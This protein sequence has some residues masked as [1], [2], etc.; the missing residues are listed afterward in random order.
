M[1]YLNAKSYCLLKNSVMNFLGL[2][3]QDY[4]KIID[5][6]LC[7]NDVDE[8]VNKIV[9][10]RVKTELELIQMF[11]LSRRLNNSNL[12][13]NENLRN[14]LL[15]KS[16][17]TE[18]FKQY[19]VS[20][21]KNNNKINLLYKNVVVNISN[22]KYDDYNGNIEFRLETDY[23]INGFAFREDLEKNDYYSSL[24]RGPEILYEIY[25]L[26]NIDNMID[27][28]ISN[29]EYYCFEYLIPMSKI[30]FDVN[31]S[32]ITNLEKTKFFLK[33]VLKYLYYEMLGHGS[34]NL[35]LR[36]SDNENLKKEWYK[37]SE[38]L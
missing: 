16:V 31:D 22:A 10:K 6:I 32:C 33:E 26:L 14:L 36:L 20:F 11:H 24:S 15:K 7:S 37:R 25:K 19:D 8:E 38:K 21:E 28:Y 17:I 34:D 2:S 13:E 5:M 1:K 23:C 9:E 35:V 30:I 27:D 29:S 3:H 12:F 18:F 4:S